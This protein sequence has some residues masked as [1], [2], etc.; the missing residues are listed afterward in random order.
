MPVTQIRQR[1][2]QGTIRTDWDLRV[3]Y[4]LSDSPSVKMSN[5]SPA[6]EGTTFE[7]LWST[8]EPDS[9]YFDLPQ[10]SHSN[11]S[12]VSNQTEVNMD[13]YQMRNMN[14]SIMIIIDGHTGSPFLLVA[15]PL[16]KC[17]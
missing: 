12:E 7:H 13:A 10:S 6:D 15:V 16:V 8:L 9:N 14:E 2:V 11:N 3:I 1:T 4:P 5:S 17:Y